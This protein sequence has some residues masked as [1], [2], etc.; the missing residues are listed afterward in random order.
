MPPLQISSE[1]NRIILALISPTNYRKDSLQL[2][3]EI[4]QAGFKVIF[5]AIHQPCASLREYYAGQGIDITRIYFIDAIT[6]YAV[7]SVPPPDDHILYLNKPG[8]HTA[9][10]I[11]VTET[12]RQLGSERVVIYIDS[13]NALLIYSDSVNLSRFI[14]FITSKLRILNVAG[15]YVAV[16]KGLDAILLSQLNAFAD[17]MIDVSGVQAGNEKTI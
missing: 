8:D 1:E 11:A 2:L 9:L 6:K 15:I 17:E 4:L 16:E 14:H 3:R 10:G 13:I 5:I 7:G 12:F